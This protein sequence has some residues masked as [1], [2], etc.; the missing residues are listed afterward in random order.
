M[1]FPVMDPCVALTGPVA[2]NDAFAFF[3]ISHLQL[4]SSLFFK[5]KNISDM[6]MKTQ[7]NHGRK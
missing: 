6:M 4:G 3:N 1:C 7:L 2:E 5:K